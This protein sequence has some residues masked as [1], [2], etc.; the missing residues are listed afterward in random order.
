MHPSLPACFRTALV[1]AC[2]GSLPVSAEIPLIGR[3]KMKEVP[4]SEE[5]AAQEAEAQKR[6]QEAVT[7]KNAG[8]HEKAEGELEAIVERFPLTKTAATAQFELGMVREAQGKPL[9]AFDEYQKLIE[10]YRDSELFGEALRR[11]YELASLAMNGKASTFFGVMPA[12][13]QPSRVVELFDKVAANAPRSAYAPLSLYSIGVL[14]RD[15]GR[16]AEAIASFQKILDEYPDDPKAKD[17]ALEI[18]AIREGR[19]TRDDSQFRQRQLEMEKFRTD[20]ANDP[21]SQDLGAKVAELEERDSAKKFETGQYYERKGNP[22]AAAIY[23]LDVREG[24]SSYAGAQARLA[25]IKAADPN[26]LLEP[27]A[28]RTRV[29][30]QE[31]AVA[32]PDYN[33]PPPPKLEAPSKPAMRASAEEVVPIPVP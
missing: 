19:R 20:Y 12:K 18:I 9:K 31:N 4:A 2:L 6:L 23:Y 3:D 7:A 27:S 25:A 33:G 24:T 26:V 32:R 8:R 1:G 30:A 28:P 11:Q 17:A 5:L 22:K 13:A 10:T 14:E 29:V 16:R 21:R 15:A